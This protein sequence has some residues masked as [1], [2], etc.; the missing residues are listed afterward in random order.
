MNKPLNLRQLNGPN[1]D[2]IVNEVVISDVVITVVDY[3]RMQV[4]GWGNDSLGYH[5][6]S[7]PTRTRT[8]IKKEDG[9]L[10]F[11]SGR[12]KILYIDDMATSMN[13]VKLA[14]VSE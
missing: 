10:L 3:D 13:H 6:S 2:L 11:M 5:A 7:A 1:V 9:A 8:R 4:G 12:I 14:I